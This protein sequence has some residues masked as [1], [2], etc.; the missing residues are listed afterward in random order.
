MENLSEQCMKVQ[1][2]SEKFA[3][4][5]IERIRKKSN[6]S[7]IPMRAYYCDKCNFWHV[8]SKSDTNTE[9]IAEL[10]KLNDELKL[11]NEELQKAL[12]ICRVSKDP[13]LSKE[14]K[15]AIKKDIRVIELQEQVTSLRTRMKQLTRDNST[16]IAKNIDYQK[17]L[18]VYER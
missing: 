10:N 3:L 4:E 18:E 15:L 1:Y 8:T 7:R 6:R 12:N 11:K 5:D 13:K 16:L 9:R 2:T 14:E 17:K